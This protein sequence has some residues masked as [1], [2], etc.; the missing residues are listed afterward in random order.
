MEP[1]DP[2]NSQSENAYIPPASGPVT[3]GPEFQGPPVMTKA[4]FSAACGLFSLPTCF[5]LGIPSIILGIAAILLGIWVRKNY[6]GNTASEMA[7]VL[8]WVGTIT[9][10]LGILLGLLALLFWILTGS[11]SVLGAFSESGR[12]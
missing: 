3:G 2:Q 7:N 6:R 10:A 9:G 4:A 1:N 12:Y 5:C 11:L 8:S